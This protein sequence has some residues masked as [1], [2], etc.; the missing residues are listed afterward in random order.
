MMTPQDIQRIAQRLPEPVGRESERTRLD[1]LYRQVVQQGGFH[2]LV[3]TGDGGMGKTYLLD[4]MR[5]KWAQD[6]TLVL[7]ATL[8]DLYDT[9]NHH[10]EGFWA[11]WME[12][13]AGEERL[14]HV[15]SA[16]QERREALHRARQRGDIA[17]IQET[18]DALSWT[19]QTEWASLSRNYPWVVLLDTVERWVYP[20]GADRVAYAPAWKWWLE[21]LQ[22]PQRPENGLLILAGR[23]ERTRYLLKALRALPNVQI[24]HL[25]LPPLT[26]EET[27]Q[28]LEA[29]GISVSDDEVRRI[30]RD[31][32][33]HPLRLTLFAYLY[34][35]DRRRAFEA[36]QRTE[37]GGR[38]SWRPLVEAW[39]NIRPWTQVLPPLAVAERGADATILA[40]MDAGGDEEKAKHKHRSFSQALESVQDTA[41]VKKRTLLTLS[42]P[43]FGQPYCLGPA[44][45]F[46]LH[47]EMYAWARWF[48]LPRSDRVQRWLELLADEALARLRLARERLGE[49]Y[50]RIAEGTLL[51]N[52]VENATKDKSQGS[53]WDL[54]QELWMWEQVRQQAEM[55]RL[56]YLLRADPERGA[57]Q[58]VRLVWEAY[59]L[60]RDDVA[61]A[62]EVEI[63]EYLQATAPPAASPWFPAP[64]P[65]LRALLEVLLSLQPAWQAFWYPARNAKEELSRARMV[66]AEG[67]RV[68][69]NATALAE[70]MR[71]LL[72][73]WLGLVEVEAL[74][75]A[76]EEERLDIALTRLQEARR[77]LET[78]TVP[79]SWRWYRDWVTALLER[80][81]AY[82]HRAR[83]EWDAAL[84]H[85]RRALP[86]LNR[87]PV[88]YEQAVAANDSGF[89]LLHLGRL[90]KGEARVRQALSIR[91][92]YGWALGMGLSL[93]TLAHAALAAGQYQ[94][95]LVLAR[96]A[97][98]LFERLDYARGI[99]FAALVKAEAYR[100]LGDDPLTTTAKTRR[101]SY[102]QALRAA[103][104]AEGIFTQQVQDWTYEL[105]ALDEVG[106][107]NRQLAL[108]HLAH[109][110]DD[111][112]V[113][114]QYARAARSAFAAV[115]RRVGSRSLEGIVNRVNAFALEAALAK[116]G[117]AD[118]LRDQAQ[119]LLQDI[120]Q[121]CPDLRSL[122][123]SSNLDARCRELAVQKGKSLFVLARTLFRL[124]REAV[125]EAQR[126]A[127]L[128]MAGD[129]FLEALE[130]SRLAGER[131][132]TLRL[133]QQQLESDVRTSLYGEHLSLEHL[134]KL[135][136]GA[137]E[138]A[139]RLGKPYEETL[140]AR[141]LGE[142]LED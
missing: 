113:S 34:S 128:R 74:R 62:A 20:L 24:E 1:A 78:L 95:A 85:F 19:L 119:A 136:E 38:E 117:Q 12:A 118:A 140:F 130:F 3:L 102:E 139:T 43:G 45:R 46:F 54:E 115:V 41:F 37:A 111:I 73:V 100:R 29:L 122:P 36:L 125:D 15:Y 91:R 79:N 120:E 21:W 108:W 109:S 5:R 31:T 57:R 112:E 98:R 89:V 116:L 25:A 121:V 63:L 65:A 101:R 47:D 59:A 93:N 58:Y 23:P 87:L 105:R 72:K 99:G 138:A 33:G 135:Q 110:D 114:Q 4:H 76:G 86:L 66:V 61:R 142:I 71:I 7:P 96:Q 124:A 129:H 133:A 48:V 131:Y 64:S 40:L 60:T 70:S 52:V 103:R 18:R 32:G 67:T 90:D 53:D 51:N 27:Q 84:E 68:I 56:A 11:S 49:L 97:R 104:E 35:S 77:I 80:V 8:I 16:Y 126:V 55:D 82:V 6:G 137:R 88:R 127:L 14:V 30:R 107:V 81:W 134:K 83:G 132:P 42:R 17:A 75:R 39:Y 94:K 123:A 2:V 22:G 44:L 10:R 9:V 50:L 69:D 28:Y 13:Y 141:V 26:V 106:R 92:R